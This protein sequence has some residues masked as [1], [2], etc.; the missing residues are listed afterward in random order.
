MRRLGTILD[1]TVW[2]YGPIAAIS[3]TGPALAPGSCDDA[4]GGAITGQAWRAGVDIAAGTDA[5]APWTDKWPDLFHEIDALVEKAG[6]TPAAAIRSATVI[7]ARAAGQ[8]HDMGSIEPGKLANM[9]VLARDP[10]TD[11]ANLKS[12]VMTIKR[13]HAYERRRF[14]PLVA[15][16]VTDQ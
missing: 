13:G 8:A 14:L 15:G 6:M 12:I 9:V 5:V 1:A 10:T 16:D 3:T 7:G 11:C 2:T 4:V